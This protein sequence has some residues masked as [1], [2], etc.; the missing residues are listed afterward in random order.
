MASTDAEMSV[1]PVM[2]ADRLGV[3]AAVNAL[4]VRVDDSSV[5][6]QRDAEEVNAPLPALV[7]VTDRSGDA[8]YPSFKAIIAG[9]KKPVITWSLADLGIAPDRVGAATAGT[10]V[11]AV[12]PR[13][14]RKAGTVIT[15]EDDAAVRL[16]DFLAANNLL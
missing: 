3:P 5:T 14:P 7:S 9:K 4:A 12:R 6:V 1:V 16:A 10:V 11:R 13:P 15:A 2:V 8:R